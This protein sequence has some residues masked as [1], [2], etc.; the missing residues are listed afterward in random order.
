M[1]HTNPPAHTQ[2]RIMRMALAASVSALLLS[3]SMGAQAAN[4]FDPR[5]STLSLDNVQFAGKNY[6]FINAAVMAYDILG[7]DDPGAGVTAFDP[8]TNKLTLEYVIVDGTKY[9]NVA[10]RLNRFELRGQIAPPSDLPV[11]QAPAPTYPAGSNELTA[12][13]LINDARVRCGSGRLTQN[14]SL[15]LAAQKHGL[16]LSWTPNILLNR[17]L[18]IEDPSGVDFYAATPQ[19]RA[20]KAG[21]A[22]TVDESV[23]AE[24]NVLFA[25]K[26]AMAIPRNIAWL[27][28]PARLDV[29]ISHVIGSGPLGMNN[30]EVML[31]TPT[32]STPPNVT[33]VR[34]F[35][36]EGSTGLIPY[37]LSNALPKDVSAEPGMGQVVVVNGDPQSLRVTEASITGPNGPVPILGIMGDGNTPDPRGV[38]TRG[39]AAVIPAPMTENTTYRVSIKGSNKGVPF[40]QEFSFQTGKAR[41]W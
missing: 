27:M 7:V 22:G 2:G 34:T 30:L 36:C 40:T 16:Y 10:V 5:T 41:A 23:S 1:S 19:E 33:A 11:L 13:Q 35:P 12:Y 24:N 38:L 17:N 25:F 39:A 26:V 20:T 32:G 18:S 31:G 3:F 14:A 6:Q 37:G 8:A 9:R 28:D 15:D 29:G 4:T 21:Y